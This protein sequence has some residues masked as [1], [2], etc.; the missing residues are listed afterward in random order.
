[1]TNTVGYMEFYHENEAEQFVFYRIPKLLFTDERFSNISTDAKLLYA[2]LLDRMSLSKKNGWV[3]DNKRVYIY[4][5]NQEIMDELNIR[6]E[7][8]TKILAELDSQKGCGLIQRKRQGQ[9]KPSKIYVMKF[10]SKQT[11]N[12]MDVEEDYLKDDDFLDFPRRITLCKGGESNFQ[13]FENQISKNSENEIPDFRKSKCNDNIYNN[14]EINDTEY[15]K[16]YLILSYLIKV[17]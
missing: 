4:F 13:T 3:D 5:S 2:L 11:D 12:V 7:K 1:M 10:T 6:S 9:G 14:T 17:V 8:C 15:S 16:S